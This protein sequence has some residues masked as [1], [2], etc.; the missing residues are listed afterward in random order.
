VTS[1]SKRQQRVRQ[2]SRRKRDLAAV[3]G[4]S[5]GRKTE[6]WQASAAMLERRSEEARLAREDREARLRPQ[7]EETTAASEAW[8]HAQ[9]ALAAAL[10]ASA[11]AL[12]VEPF[13]CLGEVNGALCLEGPPAIFGWAERRY[14]GLIGEAVR[15]RS[16]YR[17]VFLFLA[18]DPTSN[19]TDGLL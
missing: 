11:F 9:A 5:S 14:G 3:R 13:A 16:D 12:W 17:G 1:V 2:G 7:I 6:R 4:S 19:E 15:G 8:A 18:A 10:P